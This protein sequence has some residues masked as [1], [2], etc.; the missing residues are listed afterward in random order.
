MKIETDNDGGCE[1]TGIE[2]PVA[3]T[4]GCPAGIGP[5]IIL[6]FFQAGGK[7]GKSFPVVVV[8]S[9]KILEQTSRQLGLPRPVCPWNPGDTVVPGTVPVFST[10]E[11]SFHGLESGLA[12]KATALAMIGWIE[13]A[14][15]LIGDGC[16]SAM[17]TCPISKTGLR[18]AG[19]PW[20]GHTEMLA[21][22]TGADK[23]RMMM[24]G[25]RLRVV[26][27]TIHEPLARVSSLLSKE[28][29]V[30]CIATTVESLVRDFGLE[31]PRV[32]VSGLNPH[33]GEDSMF[34]FEEEKII[35][36]AVQAFSDSTTLVSG[37]WPPDTVYYRAA[38]GG[39]DAVVAPYHDQG[40]IPFKLL[41]FKD[42]V[43]VT[44]GL[45]IVR[46]SVDHGTAYDIAGK[47]LA[48]FSSLAAAVK[49]AASFVVNR[50]RERCNRG[51]A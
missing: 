18:L 1:L 28:N 17:V 19:S 27:V 10:G 4:M 29:V 37:P 38:A 50:G 51:M 6:K 30:D 12:N 49:L 46:T 16:V 32:A 33:A 41:H 11:D 40:L 7:T 43:N 22:L 23:Y 26:L 44:L 15:K 36:P 5:E 20:P 2:Q 25:S 24:A 8:G 47:N 13:Q 48:D 14:V 9:Q 39:F 31:R 45:P 35:R 21:S 3:I 34:G 42:G